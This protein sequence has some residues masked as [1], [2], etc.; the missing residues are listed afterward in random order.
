MFSLTMYILCSS[1]TGP[2]YND[3]MAG[4]EVWKEEESK[5]IVY[6]NMLSA[7]C[8]QSWPLL[9]NHDSGLPKESKRLTSQKSSVSHSTCNQ[10]LRFPGPCPTLFWP[11]FL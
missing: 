2:P 3:W 10:E 5:G 11:G 6:K 1:I 8:R 7:M 9:R 4:D